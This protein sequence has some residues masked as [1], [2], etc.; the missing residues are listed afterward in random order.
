MYLITLEII[1]NGLKH[2]KANNICIE[3]FGY[4]NDYLLLYG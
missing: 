1:N 4:P 2:E 3:L